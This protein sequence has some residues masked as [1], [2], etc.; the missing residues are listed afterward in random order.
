MHWDRLVS[1]YAA[2]IVAIVRFRSPE[3]A[4]RSRQL[5]RVPAGSAMVMMPL[6]STALLSFEG[7]WS[8]STGSAPHFT[9]DFPARCRLAA[10]RLQQNDAS[11]IEVED[12]AC[13][14]QSGYLR[15]ANGDVVLYRMP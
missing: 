7:P 10:R 9:R 4:R 15:I 8:T 1:D 6:A 12:L 5:E 2:G 3:V 11:V 13:F 14:C